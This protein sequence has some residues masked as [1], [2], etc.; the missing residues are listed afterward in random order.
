MN[1]GPISEIRRRF[2]QNPQF[3]VANTVLLLLAAT[4]ILRNAWVCDDAYITFRTIDNFVH[5]YGLTWNIIERVQTYTHPLWMMLNLVV[6][7]ITREAFFT[8]IYL[9]LI[10][11]IAA[12]GIVAFCLS[13]SWKTS[14]L[15]VFILVL[16]KA[17]VDFSTSGLE[18]PLTHLLLVIFVYIFVF[19]PHTLRTLGILSLIASLGALTRPDSLLL[20]APAV[21]AYFFTVRSWRAVVVVL[22]GAVPLVV[23]EAFSVF[24]YGSF[25]PNTAYAKLNTGIAAVELWRQGGYYF[26]N[27]LTT[28]PLTLTAIVIAVVLP[29][30]FKRSGLIPLAIGIVIYLLY[31]MS[32]GGDFM[33]GRYFSAPLMLAVAIIL[34]TRITRRVPILLGAMTVVLVLGLIPS[35]SPV[36]TT[37]AYS[38]TAGQY[39]KLKAGPGSNRANH[40]IMDEKAFYFPWSSWLNAKPGRAMPDHDWAS[41]GRAI[42]HE[43]PQLVTK[44]TV[45][46]FGYFAGPYV[47]VLDNMA[48]GDPLLARLPAAEHDEF[49]IGHFVR[50]VPE[51]YI[52]TIK[53]GRN[54]I[55]DPNLAHFY[56][57]LAY[58]TQ[59]PLW[60]AKR[61][62][63]AIELAF[64]VY[65]HYLTSYEQ[66]Q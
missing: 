25:V 16:S 31:V 63:E 60:D 29:F 11:S 15:A 21:I 52:E 42:S 10:V 64:G 54:Q 23:W 55:V 33:S 62:V 39:E 48:L 19:R 51:G 34:L 4:I 38:L 61:I 36:Y 66:N 28:D 44:S 2:S 40:N 65:D 13:D 37:S 14:V 53:S 45:G 32:I 41:Q 24:Y 5:G 47:H 46:Y 3:F 49:I 58:V 18:N 20:Y 8:S 35:R 56:Q 26:L 17:Y 27:S 59:G 6:Y 43:G 50:D 9:S 22:T 30:I 1:A 7:S 12:V 57:K